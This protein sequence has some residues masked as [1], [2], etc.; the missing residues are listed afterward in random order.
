MTFMRLKK[1]TATETLTS[2]CTE[3]TDN[4]EKTNYIYISPVFEEN[5]FLKTYLKLITLITKITY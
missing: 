3:L 4:N 2:L 5:I 1:L